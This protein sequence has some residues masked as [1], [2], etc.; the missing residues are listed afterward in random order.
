[1]EKY[2]HTFAEL[3]TFARAI[4]RALSQSVRVGSND[5]PAH[6]IGVL[7][8]SGGYSLCAA[9][10]AILWEGR[11]V[12]PLSAEAPVHRIDSILADAMVRVV[13]ITDEESAAVATKASF[14][15]I[16]IL[17]IR[18][19]EATA[20]DDGPVL[21]DSEHDV[22]TSFDSYEKAAASNGDAYLYYT[23]GSS[24]EPKGVS[25]GHGPMVNRLRW[26]REWWPFAED[27]VCCQRV[28]HVFI[29][30]VAEIFGPLSCGIPIIVVPSAVRK[31][32]VLLR[33]FIITHGVTRITLVPT[34]ARRIAEA[35]LMVPST[36]G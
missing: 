12:V 30:F 27:E 7:A 28:E 20:A 36:F 19:L 16:S 32:P 2:G 22:S 33:D 31:N 24:G 15:N 5:A 34:L 14:Q 3:R 8:A 25:S 17:D 18:R 26:M 4:R 11:T 1:D 6:N 29:D 21:C 23:S 35:A 13:L 9:W 10:L